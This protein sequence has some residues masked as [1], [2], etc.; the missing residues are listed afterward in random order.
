MPMVSRPGSTSSLKP[1]AAPDVCTIPT[2]AP[3]STADNT[4]TKDKLA[5]MIKAKG[6]AA[7]E[8]PVLDS[9]ARGL[10][11]D[12]GMSSL[13]GQNGTVAAPP[14]TVSPSTSTSKVVL[15]R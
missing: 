8:T 11:G 3:A 4:S 6:S 5:A 13:I 12:N 14:E 7:S 10:I 2:T 1:L 15:D 9:A